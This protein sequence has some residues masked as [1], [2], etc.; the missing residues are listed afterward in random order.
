[1]SS[2]CFFKQHPVR[3][4]SSGYTLVAKGVE[5]VDLGR[6]RHENDLYDRLQPIQG[7]HVP[8]CLGSVDL[9]LPY[10][11]DSDV[12]EHFLFLSWAGLPLFDFI[13]RTTK[14]DIVNKVTEAYKRIHRLHILHHDAEPRNIMYDPKS[15]NVMIVDFERAEFRSRQPLGP[16][17]PNAQN[18]RKRR[19]T[20]K[21][22]KDDFEKEQESVTGSLLRLMK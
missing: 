4:S 5:R 14:V 12:F 15:G 19:R 21:Q 16:L 1:M 2:Y 7:T 18:Q 3:L 13:N 10:Y 9:V 17:G 6:L 22:G 20:Q 11:Y 8:V